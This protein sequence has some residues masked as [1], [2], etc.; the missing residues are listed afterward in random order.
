MLTRLIY[1]S[2][3]NDPLTPDS[4]QTIVTH[5]RQANTRRHL[6]GMLVFDHRAFLQVLE[7][8]REV[9]SD[10]YGRIAADKRHRRLVLMDVLPID[11]RLFAD[12][13]MGFAAADALGREQFLRFGGGDS[14][15]PHSMTAAAGLGLLRALAQHV[16]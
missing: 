13:G 16:K 1:A 11:E 4:V 10:V 15:D 3:A 14:F 9:V 8:Q 12:W 5:A 2:E 6:T 7:G